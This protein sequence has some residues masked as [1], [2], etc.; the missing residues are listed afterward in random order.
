MAKNKTVVLPSIRNHHLLGGSSD[1]VS[2]P[3]GMPTF[4]VMFIN[5]TR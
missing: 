2:L 5:Q 1:H 3:L 4:L